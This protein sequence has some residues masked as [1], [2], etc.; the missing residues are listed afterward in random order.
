MRPKKTFIS[1]TIL[2]VIFLAV[3]AGLSACNPKTELIQVG[4]HDIGGVITGPKGPEAG[5]W[6]I[7]ET[8]ELPTRYAKIVVT[9]DNG[10]YL[11][12]GLPAAN[13]AVW[14]RGYGL[15]DSPK[16]EA[17][18]GSTV[19]LDAVEAPDRHAAA[20][21]YRSGCWVSLLQVRY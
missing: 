5:V 10:Q 17:K 11:I 20:Q 9:D 12:P 6:V 3:L 7:A 18:P 15:V 13:Y 14:V 19:N 8:H 1:T 21:S 4:E 16:K 2:H